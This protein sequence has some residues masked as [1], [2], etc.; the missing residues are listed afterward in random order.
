[1]DF[2]SIIIPAFN[3]ER[4]LETTLRSVSEA[5]DSECEVIVVNDGS[6]DRTGDIAR[7]FADSDPRFTVIDIE[8]VG[9]SAARRAGFLE[10]QGDYIMFV[11]SDD[12]L[13]ADSV[14]EQ[15]RLLDLYVNTS[16]EPV[17]GYTDGR[18]KIV[19]ANTVERIGADDR[20]LISGSRRALT[21][22]EYA[23]EI[24]TGVLPGFLPGHLYARD[25]I[26][27]ID[28]D[29]SPNITHQENYYLLLSFAMHV[30]RTAPGKRL[31][32]VAPSFIG[33][34]Y[35]RRAGSQ[36]ALMALTPAGLERVWRHISNLGLPEPQLTLWA[37][38]LLN[39][40]FVER[41]IP[42]PSGYPMAAD[43]RRR[44][45]A[46]GKNLSEKHR[47]MVNALG[48]LR[49]RTRI[50]RELARSAGLTSIR[51]HLSI[52]VPCRHNVAMLERTV[53][54][55]FS[56]G[57]RNLEV[58]IIDVDNTHSERVAINAMAIHYA[59]VRVVK[60]APGTSNGAAAI[61]G[62]R[63]AQGLSVAVLRP[64]DLCSAAGLYEA[65]TRIDY[66]ADAVIPNFRFYHRFLRLKGKLHSYAAMRSTHESRNAEHTAANATENVYSTVVKALDRLE[67]GRYADMHGI[68]WR[69]DF[70]Q[71]HLPEDKAFDDVPSEALS[72]AIMRHFTAQPVR[73]VSQDKNSA[74]AF[75]FLTY[76]LKR[77]LQSKRHRLFET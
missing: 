71:A 31:V 59:R 37:I 18:P 15:R 39:R 66:G 45:L 36:S 10:S 38:E 40:V 74:V 6:G 23:T 3:A 32:L 7:A 60:I 43:L 8:H 46:L 64:G 17:E 5:I 52:V 9:P 21:G 58:V 33:Y 76:S 1:M 41:G 22:L 53:A 42:F 54:S 57:F 34:R 28:W 29:D 25:L 44:G 35:I 48:S 70:I 11:D 49:K 61:A 19:V 72:V 55:V 75:Y 24:L 4:W 69:T 16:D 30:E 77:L 47:E 12:L 51:P 68:V 13:P 27:A 50:A 26:E 73:I 2:V 14:R 56:M 62:L 63:A 67:E 65:V 20:L